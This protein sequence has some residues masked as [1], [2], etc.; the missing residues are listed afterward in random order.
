MPEF[1]DTLTVRPSGPLRGHLRVPG[2]KS[3]SHRALILGAIADGRTSI[4]GLLAS[5]D[6]DATRRCLEAIGVA[7]EERGDT[8]HVEGAGRD[9][10]LEPAAALDCGNSGTTMRLLAGV[11]AGQP[12]TSRLSGDVSLSRRPMDRIAEPLQAMGAAVVTSDEGRP[13]LEI[14]GQRPLSAVSH[15]SP[16]ASAQ[17]KS[18]VLLAG[19]YADGRTQI[20]EPAPSRDHT[21]RMLEAFGCPVDRLG[22]RIAIDGGKP[23]KATALTVPGDASAAAFLA[24]AATLVPGSDIVLEGVGMNPTRSGFIAVLHQM[25]ADITVTEEREEG[26]EPVADLRIRHARLDGAVVDPAWVPSAIDEF[27]ALFVAAAAANGETTI[28]GAG[29]LR[30][31]ESDRIAVMARALAIL[32]VQV[33]ERPDGMQLDGGGIAGGQVDA[34]GDHRCA[35][36]LAVAALAAG[37]PIHIT[38]ASG[39]AVSY[40]GFL[41][42]LAVLSG[43]QDENG[44]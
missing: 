1:P 44:P 24:V 33:A 12:F 7:I 37:A 40:P 28:S 38:G 11:L 39:M 32:G 10:L 25:G 22:N 43:Q 4:R 34:A 29:E 2:D 6:I 5:E 16:V 18:C 41:D 26:G 27:P 19:L 14:R 35:M 8:V 31:K 3:I 9:G 36:A 15:V 21:E 30:V 23:L 20:T 42:D 13:P 17:V